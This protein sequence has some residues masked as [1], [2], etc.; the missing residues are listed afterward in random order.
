MSKR[1]FQPLALLFAVLMLFFSLSAGAQSLDDP[2]LDLTPN[3]VTVNAEVQ[4]AVGGLN[5]QF[6]YTLDWG[7]SSSTDVPR[8]TTATLRHRFSTSGTFTAVLRRNG[9]TPVAR[10]TIKVTPAPTCVLELTPNPAEVGSAVKATLSGLPAGASLRIN[11]GDSS[12][13]D[14]SP[15]GQG[16]ATLSHPYGAA[17]GYTV[18]VTTTSALANVVTLCRGSVKVEAVPVGLELSP[19]PA[20]VGQTVTARLSNLNPNAGGY[21]LNWGDGSPTENVPDGRTATLTHAYGK[22]GTFPVTVNLSDSRPVVARASVT[23]NALTCTLEVPAETT[24]GS[25]TTAKVSGLPPQRNFELRWGDGNSDPFLSSTTGTA[26]LS[27]TFDKVGGYVVAIFNGES[28]VCR[29]QTRVTVPLPTLEVNPTNTTIARPVDVKAGNLLP[30]LTYSLEYGD[31][32]KED[33]SGKASSS[34]KHTYAK[35]GTYTLKLSYPGG[36]PVTATVT[37]TLPTCTITLDPPSE[38]IVG[39]LVKATVAGLPPALEVN[40]NWGDGSSAEPQTANGAGGF[41]AN[42]T[43][44]AL[45]QAALVSV[46]YTLPAATAPVRLCQAPPLRV[47]LPPAQEVITPSSDPKALIPMSFALSNLLKGDLFEYN[48]D[49]GDNSSDPVTVKGDGTATLPHTYAKVGL[50]T[51]RLILTVG[52]NVNSGK[53]TRASAVVNVTSPINISKLDVTFVVPEVAKALQV[54]Q[55]APLEAEISLD[56]AGA[57]TLSGD[58]TLDGTLLESETYDL[59]K[60]KTSDSFRLKNIDT[61]KLGAHVLKFTVKSLEVDGTAIPL[62][63]GLQAAAAQTLSYEVIFKEDPTTLNIGGFIVNISSLS[64]RSVTAFAGKGVHELIVGGTAAGK[65]DLEFSALSVV[66]TNTPGEAKVTKGQIDK[67]WDGNGFFAATP[68][69]FGRNHLY[70]TRL[71]LTPEGGKADG[72]MSIFGTVPYVSLSSGK[73][74]KPTIPQ[75]EINLQTKPGPFNPGDPQPNWGAQFSNPAIDG[76]LKVAPIYGGGL[77]I[78]QANPGGRPSSSALSTA[79]TGVGKTGKFSKISNTS[80]KGRSSSQTTSSPTMS[81]PTMSRQ[82]NAG[83]SKSQYVANLGY[84]AT[85]YSLK[86]YQDLGAV[87]FTV[88]G[89]LDSSR[90]SDFENAGKLKFSAQTLLPVSGDL[91]ASGTADIN[92]FALGKTGLALGARPDAV[93]DLSAAQSPAGLEATYGADTA[94]PDL[95]PAWM[96]LFFPKAPLDTGAY[97]ISG[98]STS[99]ATGSGKGLSGSVSSGV[100][101]GISSAASFIYATQYSGNALSSASSGKYTLSSTVAFATL[102]AAATSSGTGYPYDINVDVSYQAG[103]NLFIKKSGGSI[104]L[105]GWKFDIEDL[106]L[107]VVKTEL[108]IGGGK[109]KTRVPFLEETLPAQYTWTPEQKWNITTATTLVHD[110]GRSTV[111]TGAGVFLPSGPG[112]LALRFPDALWQIAELVKPSAGSGGG[113]GGSVKYGGLNLSSS[114]AYQVASSVLSTGGSSGSSSTFLLSSSLQSS[115][116]FALA[117]P[118]GG[119]ISVGNLLSK[120]GAASSAYVVAVKSGSSYL[121]EG[122]GELELPGL[123]IEPTGGVS[124]AGQNYVSLSGGDNLRVLGF[125]FPAYQIGVGQEKGAYYIGLNGKQSVADE[126]PA[127]NSKLKYVVQNGKNLVVTIEADGFTKTMNPS[128]KFTVKSTYREL[129]LSGSPVALYWQFVDPDGHLILADID[130]SFPIPGGGSVRIIDNSDKFEMSVNAKMVLGEGDA[131]MQV[132]ADAL[133]GNKKAT[134]TSYFYVFVNV[135]SPSSPLFSVFTVANVHAVFGGI[136]YHMKWP[137]G[138]AVKGYQK[139]PVYDAN[140]SVQIVGGLALAIEDGS[141]L[142]TAGIFVID[143]NGAF[144]IT[145]DGWFFTKLSSGYFGNQAPQARA[146][147]QVNSDGFLASLCVGP[148][149]PINPSIQC[150]DLREM[151][152][153]GVA[154]VRGAAELYIGSDFHI[155]VGAYSPDR[156]V[157][158]TFLSFAEVDGYFMMGQMPGNP[159]KPPAATAGSY[160]LWFGGHARVAYH[161]GDSGSIGAW[162]F[163]CNYSWHFDAG[164]EASADFGINL[165]PFYLD[166]KGEFH[167]WASVGASLCGLGGDI[168]A[169]VWLRGHVHTPNPTNF[170]GSASVHIGMPGPIPNIDFTVGV[171]INL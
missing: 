10:A 28:G 149:A 143:F 151:S 170:D 72:A 125:A 86:G 51:V 63:L 14:F 24:L 135:A 92:P 33:I 145:A 76:A 169:D 107:G 112:V 159:L 126:M 48:L 142:H 22:P 23:V 44:T 128:A 69:G 152:L 67:R 15:N 18:T 6:S 62:G 70:L 122:G 30:A 4:A 97:G 166:A 89:L 78:G 43:Y 171:A 144:S 98:S 141:T 94:P 160:G 104:N 101:S 139:P 59:K 54:R 153:F 66:L 45:I 161:A 21:V 165:S 74:I 29:A 167:A 39:T 100:S 150:G 133:F 115:G 113:G 168:S 73:P 116:I 20:D 49:Y 91:F 40:L 1:Y 58:W 156:R 56:Y 55:D 108:Q 8:A 136:A 27:H 75:Y 83:S 81:S 46:T 35:P 82:T 148:A 95:G 25:V 138:G 123:Q 119:E 154:T 120:V 71:L 129:P 131:G 19:N 26:S 99:S 3:P 60:T 110:F 132:D 127:V 117:S 68:T 140:A 38:A 41:T 11:W 31:G 146:F 85:S 42:H 52:Q 47:T 102:G 90:D 137:T 88:V 111:S 65:I 37:I 17:G 114:K 103:Y 36:P 12:S 34:T 93:L 130:Q 164:V 5:T 118:G 84:T 57:G 79:L 13:D 162:I 134:S 109:G 157:R 87:K 124:L 77:S 155:Y 50:Y 61:S 53:T 96:G 105:G 7:D 9:E 80:V 121:K 106:F 16:A 158:A 32:D 163:S 64:N 147:I 2:T